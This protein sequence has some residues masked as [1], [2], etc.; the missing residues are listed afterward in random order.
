MLSS[1]FVSCLFGGT[2]FSQMPVPYPN[3]AHLFRFRKKKPPKFPL[4][5][6]SQNHV[7]HMRRR[8]VDAACGQKVTFN[9]VSYERPN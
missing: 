9:V 5:E 3:D 8:Q 2:V 1:F 6:T 7:A 4:K